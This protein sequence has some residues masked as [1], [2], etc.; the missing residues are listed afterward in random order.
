MK[1]NIK[2]VLEKYILLCLKYI[3]VILKWKIIRIKHI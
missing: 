3:F 1:L 2:H